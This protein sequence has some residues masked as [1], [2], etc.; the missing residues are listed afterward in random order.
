MYAREAGF[1][2]L[3]L[4]PASAAGGVAMLKALGGPL[5]DMNFCPTGGITAET[6]PQYLACGNVI[7][8]GGSW[9]TPKSAL[10]A[11]D[12]KAITELAKA[13]SQMR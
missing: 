12:W 3:K 13:A 1:H 8:V 2:Q 9:L 4:F 6:A 10:A 7:C 5:P 11:G